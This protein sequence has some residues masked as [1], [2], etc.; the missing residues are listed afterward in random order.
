[1]QYLNT[2]YGSC[3]T[4]AYK[5]GEATATDM[6]FGALAAGIMPAASGASAKESYAFG[7][8]VDACTVYRSIYAFL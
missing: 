5:T 4:Y 7:Y 1:M 8:L 3:D 6:R 2:W